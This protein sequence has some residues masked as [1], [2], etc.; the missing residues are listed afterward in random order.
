MVRVLATTAPLAGAVMLHLAREMGFFLAT[1]STRPAEGGRECFS[2]A[3][4]TTKKIEAEP[5]A[6]AP[7]E[8]VLLDLK[9][10]F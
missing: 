3:A 9:K 6:P 7:S 4:K 5:P 2:Y 8:T 10:P 1:S